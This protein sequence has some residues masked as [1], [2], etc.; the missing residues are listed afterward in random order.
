M[1]KL[2]GEI[3]V[4]NTARGMKNK[5]FFAVSVTG[6]ILV[7]GV[8]LFVLAMNRV[9]VTGECSALS[10]IPWFGAKLPSRNLGRIQYV[11]KKYRQVFA[12]VNTTTQEF[13]KV[14]RELKLSVIRYRMGFDT[15]D[16]SAVDR[17]FRPTGTAVWC[18]WG[19]IGNKART[20]VRLFFEPATHG[21]L[22][23]FSMSTFRR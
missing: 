21:G 8:C 3:I 14:A 4:R 13:E 12:R 15:A 6:V 7:C 17:E 9:P 18:A 19:T 2:T 5:R 11:A 1:P 23:V 22:M 20:T 16:L 10:Q